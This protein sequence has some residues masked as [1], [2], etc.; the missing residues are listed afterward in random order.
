VTPSLAGA[1]AAALLAAAPAPRRIVDRVAA[2]V[3]GEVVTLLEVVERSGDAYVRSQDLPTGAIR[4]R[5]VAESLRRAFDAVVAEKLLESA[6]Q[7]HEVEVTEEQV[8][9]AVA[10]IKQRNGF[11]DAQLDLVLAQQGMD[12]AQFR[13]QMRK[14][15]RT[16][17]LMQYKVR[18]KIRVSDEDV[19]AYY[20]SHPGEFAGAEEVRVR[21]IFLPLPAGAGR[22]GEA[23][24]RAAAERAVE[25]IRSGESFESLA[26]EVSKG[27]SAEEGGDLGWIRRGT[28]EKALEDV[29][30]RLETAEVSPVLQAG[31]G[32]HVLQAAGRRQ[33]GGRD[34]DQVKDEIRERLAQEQFASY[35]DQYVAELRRGAAIQVR[36]PELDAAAGN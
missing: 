16:L 9:A 10:D 1:L 36:I 32:L 22:D 31:S 18:A 25:R 27:P 12:R 21:H 5:A 3:N 4:D 11:D 35:R 28:I 7:Q 23:R 24:V 8:D 26:K 13:E 2:T 6:A 33:G 29:V 30:F 14:E 17:S 15:I 34:F 19:R 20:Q